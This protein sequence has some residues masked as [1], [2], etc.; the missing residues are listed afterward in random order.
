MSR[1]RLERGIQVA[2]RLCQCT[3]TRDKVATDLAVGRCIGE[4]RHGHSTATH[5]RAA[6]RSRRAAHAC[7]RAAGSRAPQRAMANGHNVRCAFCMLYII[8]ICVMF[9]VVQVVSGSV[10]THEVVYNHVHHVCNKALAITCR[11][12]VKED[13]GEMRTFTQSE[14]S[15]QVTPDSGKYL[16]NSVATQAVPLPRPGM[17]WQF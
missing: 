6:E 11:R 16:G 12:A 17:R 5:A 9:Q 7:C 10:G 15:A 13:Q 1:E 2:L 4:C 8:S 3:K 14:S